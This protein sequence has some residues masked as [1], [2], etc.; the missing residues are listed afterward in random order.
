VELRNPAPESPLANQLGLCPAPAKLADNISVR[1]PRAESINA[2]WFDIHDS[3]QFDKSFGRFAIHNKVILKY[4][5]RKFKKKS[6]VQ[7]YR[8]HGFK[9]Q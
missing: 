6:M 8:I 9:E 4:L 7:R 3:G 5:C 2:P 1:S